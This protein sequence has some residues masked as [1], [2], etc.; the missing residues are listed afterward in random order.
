MKFVIK[1]LV[2]LV[3]ILNTFRFKLAVR[4]LATARQI[5]QE[6]RQSLVSNVVCLMGNERRNNIKKL[7]GYKW[8]E[9]HT[10]ND[11]VL[12]SRFVLFRG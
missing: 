12:N 4:D 1:A 11:P 9:Q 5:R 6:T 10:K 3:R 8:W 2:L 7:V